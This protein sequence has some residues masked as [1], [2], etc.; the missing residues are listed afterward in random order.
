MRNFLLLY[1]AILVVGGY[2]QSPLSSKQLTDRITMKVPGELRNVAP[3]MQR[4]TS[5]TLAMFVS[6]DGETELALNKSQLRWSSSDIQ[7]LQ[8]F[9][10]A[11][12][13]NLYDQVN[14]ID[15]GIRE[16]SGRQFIYFEYTAEIHS[17]PNA[18]KRQTRQSSYNFI[19]YT[20]DND[21]VLIFRFNCKIN[22]QPYWQDV[23]RKS[24]KSIE[25]VEKKRKK[26]Q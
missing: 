7:L 13:L 18:F 4:N 21:G 3:T 2:A 9:Y 6:R 23:I 24:M 25:F 10:K 11:N 14:M 1:L 22:R 20:V 26:K 19:Q 16:I 15:E 8:Q 17:R 12:I 5:P